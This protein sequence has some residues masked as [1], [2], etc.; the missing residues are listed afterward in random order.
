MSTSE[1]L[2]CHLIRSDRNANLGVDR[3]RIRAASQFVHLFSAHRSSSFWFYFTERVF[4]QLLLPPLFIQEERTSG[5]FRRTTRLL[6]ASGCYSLTTTVHSCGSG[7]V[8]SE[9]VTASAL[10]AAT[11][12][13]LFVRAAAIECSIGIVQMYRAEK[14]VSVR[15]SQKF[16]PGP[17]WLLLSKTYKDFFSALYY[18]AI[19]L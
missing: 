3:Q 2:T 17:A 11:I 16:L 14:K 18:V 6:V 9:R 1:F 13:S 7:R 10:Q 8:Q 15:G 4:S 19:R 5:K 12:H